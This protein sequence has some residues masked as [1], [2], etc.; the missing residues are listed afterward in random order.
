MIF[1]FYMHDRAEFRAFEADFVLWKADFWKNTG[2][3]Q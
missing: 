3:K 2:E 1:D